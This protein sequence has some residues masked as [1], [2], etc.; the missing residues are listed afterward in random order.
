MRDRR[1]A[2]D[3]VGARP[4]KQISRN[5]FI[6]LERVLVSAV[7]GPERSGLS[8]P[9]VLLARIARHIANAILRQDIEDEAG[10]IHPAAR[11]IGRAVFVIEIASRQLERHVS[12]VPNVFRIFLVVDNL[13]RQD[14]GGRS[15]FLR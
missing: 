13:A 15:F 11:R 6:E 1:I 10:A 9:N 4:E 14:R 3:A 7:D 8:Q 12:Y 2:L 5:Q